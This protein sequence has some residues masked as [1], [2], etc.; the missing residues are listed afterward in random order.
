M[1]GIS[2]LNHLGGLIDWGAVYLDIR[3]PIV[4]Q[5]GNTKS[6]KAMAAA[7]GVALGAADYAS[8][9][10]YEGK[11][12]EAYFKKRQSPSL[13]EGYTEI[14]AP[15]PAQPSG[16]SFSRSFEAVKFGLKKLNAAFYPALGP[17]KDAA[18]AYFGMSALAGFILE[19]LNPINSGAVVTP[20]AALSPSALL[21]I[22]AVYLTL[23]APKFLAA[24]FQTTLN[25]L[26][27]T[28]NLSWLRHIPGIQAYF[29][30]VVPYSSALSASLPQLAFF[31]PNMVKKMIASRWGIVPLALNVAS[32]LW[33]MKTS[34]QRTLNQD[35][36]TAFEN[37]G[38]AYDAP[39]SHI[40]TAS[41]VNWIV[42]QVIERV[43]PFGEAIETKKLWQTIA[44]LG[45]G[46]LTAAIPVTLLA[47][48]ATEEH[49]AEASST[50]SAP[51]ESTLVFCDDDDRPTTPVS[52]SSA[53]GPAHF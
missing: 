18:E 27:G 44:K 5:F 20:L 52:V 29:K 26:K 25:G 22:T 35:V 2:A 9:I 37:M 6:I 14:P 28:E 32:A 53:S 43:L 19:W 46:A 10:E 13:K 8:F 49:R 11:L 31:S 39:E 45:G 21:I 51:Q 15:E 7:L 48:A 17:L 38:V 41:N 12:V 1:S 33:N 4:A 30:H 36:A 47:I 23:Y 24:E 3:N 50:A 16:F 40:D 42:A 34:Y